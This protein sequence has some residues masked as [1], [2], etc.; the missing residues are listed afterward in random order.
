VVKSGTRDTK[1]KITGGSC[2][3]PLVS[4]TTIKRSE[5]SRTQSDPI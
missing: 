5:Q 2:S 4:S 1:T 3:I